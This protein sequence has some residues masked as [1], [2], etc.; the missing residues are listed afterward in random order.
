M[1]IPIMRGQITSAFES[2]SCVP[3]QGPCRSQLCPAG[4]RA[5]LAA[6]LP[7]FP[8]IPCN[9]PAQLPRASLRLPPDAVRKL[10]LHYLLTIKIHAVSVP[11]AMERAIGTEEACRDL[12]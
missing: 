10:Y 8:S 1:F 7:C 4:G 9:P 12:R 11:C 3:V 2:P 5:R 6:A